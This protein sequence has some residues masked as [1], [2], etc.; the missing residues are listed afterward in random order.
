MQDCQT[1]TGDGTGGRSMSANAI[2]K[3]S[4]GCFKPTPVDQS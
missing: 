2:V 1:L 4:T 3:E